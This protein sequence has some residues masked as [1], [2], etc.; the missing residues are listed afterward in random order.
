MNRNKIITFVAALTVCACQALTLTS[1][2]NPDT[3]SDTSAVSDSTV[4]TDKATEK[5]PAVT[6]PDAPADSYTVIDKNE[7]ESLLGTFNYSNYTSEA[8]TMGITNVC[9]VNATSAYYRTPS[10]EYYTQKNSNGTYTSYVKEKDS[11]SFTKIENDSAERYNNA[12]TSGAIKVDYTTSFELFKYDESI[13]AY[14]CEEM[15]MAT[16]V[17]D[18]TT[19]QIETYN[20]VIVIKNNELISV[21][22]DYKIPSLDNIS[23]TVSYSELGSTRITMPNA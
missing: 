5:H 12:K 7:W 14:K 16:L 2:D 10:E 4:S 19:I 1:C 3:P 15:L 8:K 11:T 6:I 17:A 22:F 21:T 13:K 18:G 23:G 9:N 20:T